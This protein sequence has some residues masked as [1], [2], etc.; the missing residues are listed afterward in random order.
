MSPA[1][2]VRDL[3]QRARLAASE[4]S[5]PIR[6]VLGGAGA[7]VFTLKTCSVSRGGGYNEQKHLCVS[8]QCLTLGI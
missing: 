5:L 8:S 2:G 4:A 3:S 7:R 6:T 1:P